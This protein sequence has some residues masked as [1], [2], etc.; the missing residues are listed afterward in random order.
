MTIK[1]PP[2]LFPNTIRYARGIK[3]K[4]PVLHS[5][6]NKERKIAI[7]KSGQA[8]G[9]AFIQPSFHVIKTAFQIVLLVITAI[10]AI[11]SQSA[12]LEVKNLGIEVLDGI[13]CIPFSLIKNLLFLFK[14]L[15]GVCNP[16]WVFKKA[17]KNEEEIIL[18]YQKAVKKMGTYYEKMKNPI[19]RK[20][21]RKNNIDALKD[22]DPEAA[23]LMLFAHNKFPRITEL[24]RSV[25]TY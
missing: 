25:M 24:Y 21:I 1:A 23:S 16:N 22:V 11:W 4:R 19:I 10:G 20:I 6:G 5:P 9:Y 7:I 13:V 3:E 18:V 8:L 2:F 14:G 15:A 12:R 17:N